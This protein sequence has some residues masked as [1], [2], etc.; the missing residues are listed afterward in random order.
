MTS[1]K[2]CKT[3]GYFVQYQRAVEHFNDLGLA[4]RHAERNGPARI[5]H[6]ID[7]TEIQGGAVSVLA[8]SKPCFRA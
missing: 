7:V 6:A 4:K 8:G 3:T 5:W 1:V 2:V